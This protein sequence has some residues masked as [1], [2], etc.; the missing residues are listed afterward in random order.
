[1]KKIIHL[2]VALLFVF[3]LIT[4]CAVH[5]GTNTGSGTEAQ[6][7]VEETDDT[8]EEESSMKAY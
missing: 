3:T 8:D 7:Q 1:M 5:R 4:S 2:I 6:T